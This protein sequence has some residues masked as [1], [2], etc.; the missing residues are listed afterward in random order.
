[1]VTATWNGVTIAESDQTV[2]VEGNHY[3][4][5]SAVNANYLEASD[6]S[7]ICPWKGQAQYHS[8]IVNGERNEDA[9]WY[10]PEPS[11]KAAE[12]KD[13]IAFGGGV[14]VG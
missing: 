1:M 3:F 13:H 7:T 6:T 11:A 4:P 5:R 2:M 9:A 12:I 8:L 14:K 10:Y